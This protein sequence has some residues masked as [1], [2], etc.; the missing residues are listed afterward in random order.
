MVFNSDLSKPIGVF[1]SGIG[2]L[3]V[4]QA[5]HKVL[6]NEQIIYVGDTAHMPYGDKS[7]TLIRQYAVRI[8]RY[9]LEERNCKAIVIACNTASAAAYEFLRDELKGKI[10]VINVIDPMVEFIISDD[11]IQNPGIIATKTTINS[12]VYQEKLKRRKPELH[13]AALATPLLAPMIEEGF[14]ND[15]VSQAVLHEYLENK[16]LEGIDALVLACTHYPLIKKEIEEYYQ[17]RVRVIDSA[18]VVAE[19]LKN[20]LEKESLI[21]FSKKQNDEFLVTDY[22]EH[23]EHSTRRFYGESIDLKKISLSE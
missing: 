13:F 21:H 20:I 22:S 18:M 5:I 6:P 4:A 17:S 14:Y 19:K 7:I 2:G 12:G 1:D 10:P 16:E 8:A 23:F 11:S 9:L 3:T 15:S